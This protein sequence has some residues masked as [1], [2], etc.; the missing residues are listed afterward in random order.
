MRRLKLLILPLLLLA[1]WV[2]A[3]GA[4][5]LVIAHRGASAYLPEHTL[6]A[7][8]LAYGQG[9]DFLEPDLVMTADGHLIALHDLTLEATTNVAERFPERARAD[10]GFYAIDFTLAELRSLKVGERV[11]PETGQARYPARWPVGMGQFRIVEFNELIEFTRALNRTTGRRVGLYPETKAPRFHAD[12]GQ[13]IGAALVSVLLAHD[14]PSTDLPVFIQSF[15]PEP[16]HA[17]HAK[18]GDR[19]PLIQLIGLNDWG[20]NEVDY[21]A[22]ISEQGLS[23]VAEYAVGIGPLLSLLVEGELGEATRPSQLFKQARAL[24][25]AMHP[26][27]FRREGLPAEISLEALLDLFIG[28]L[29][30]DGVFTDNPD[31]AVQRRAR[32]GAGS[33]ESLRGGY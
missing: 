16:L 8:A 23:R 18:H 11:D 31:V 5:T 33:D 13:D 7:Y 32:L 10:G 29:Q 3:A 20:M 17:I 9:A 25:L 12:H 22:M 15:E 1:G 27:T 26:Y 2:P 28:Q 6:E 14:L 4:E 21:E 19:F 30:I 24:N